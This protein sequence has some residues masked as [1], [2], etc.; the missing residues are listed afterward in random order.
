MHDKPQNKYQ[1]L[2]KN[3]NYLC[4]QMSY[5]VLLSTEL[6]LCSLFA[7]DTK[8]TRLAVSDF[9]NETIMQQMIYLSYFCHSSV[10]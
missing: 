7:C 10:L 3:H 5:C 4:L 1:Q 8:L 9:N 2:S 6:V